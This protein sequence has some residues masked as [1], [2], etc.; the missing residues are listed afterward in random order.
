MTML[1]ELRDVMA[2]DLP[3]FFQQQLD[4]D[5]NYMAAFTAKD[6]SDHAAFMARW[7]RIFADPTVVM[8]TIVVDQQVAGSVSTYAEG[9]VLEVTYWLG[10][11]YWGRGIATQALTQFLAKVQPVRPLRARVAKDHLASLRVLQ[12]CG[13]TIVGE[14]RG[15]ANARNAETEVSAHPC[16]IDIIPIYMA[17][18]QDDKRVCCA[19][20]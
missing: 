18:G 20:R 3:V 15:F 12:K 14:D 13:F 7:R 19:T 11:A 16:I 10:K 8:Q 17:I 2:D 6:P 5:A 4:P 1:L 9:N